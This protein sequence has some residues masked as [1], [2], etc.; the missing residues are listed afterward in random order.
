[1]LNEIIYGIGFEMLVNVEF[2][3]VIVLWILLF[4]NLKIALNFERR[5]DL[6]SFLDNILVFL[7][8]I[9]L[10]IFVITILRLSIIFY[11]DICVTQY[12]YL[13]AIFFCIYL[14]WL[15][16]TSIVYYELKKQRNNLTIHILELWMLISITSMLLYNLIIFLAKVYFL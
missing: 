15:L 3:N 14:I 8:K 12:L 11:F 7:F 4:C 13:S 2:W 5:D 6:I 10:S 9:N 16:F 1:M